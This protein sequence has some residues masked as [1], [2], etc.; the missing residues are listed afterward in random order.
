[1]PW[2]HVQNAEADETSAIL[3]GVRVFAEQCFGD[4]HEQSGTEVFTIWLAL[5]H[6]ETYRHSAKRAMDRMVDAHFRALQEL[7][8]P[9]IRFQGEEVTE[10]LGL[11]KR[12]GNAELHNYLMCWAMIYRLILRLKKRTVV[13]EMSSVSEIWDRHG[14]VLNSYYSLRHEFEHFDQRLPG[15]QFEEKYRQLVDSENPNGAWS[16]GWMYD[17]H[18]RLKIGD[19]SG[20]V[21]PSSVIL[22]DRIVRELRL[23][24]LE[25]ADEVFRTSEPAVHKPTSAF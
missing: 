23:A 11:S 24:M 21:S 3:R 8:E 4:D 17:E 18:G 12:E 14:K 7:Q 6:I 10:G 9:P 22:L 13:L 15:E 5:Y 1:M 2:R 25:E 16:Y 19:A 20:D